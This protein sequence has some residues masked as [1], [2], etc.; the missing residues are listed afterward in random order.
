MCSMSNRARSMW[1]PMAKPNTI[2]PKSVPEKAEAASSPAGETHNTH[3]EA[4]A[5]LLALAAK[6]VRKPR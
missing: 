4:F 6:T 3:K 5:A 1:H 2:P